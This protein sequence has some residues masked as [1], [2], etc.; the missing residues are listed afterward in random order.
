MAQSGTAPTSRYPHRLQGP[1]PPCPLP[2]AQSTNLPSWV[3]LFHWCFVSHIPDVTSPRHRSSEMDLMSLCFLQLR[4]TSKRLSLQPPEEPAGHSATV[5]VLTGGQRAAK[6]T[7]GLAESFRVPGTTSKSLQNLSVL[8]RTCRV[9]PS[10]QD[11]AGEP[12][13]CLA[14]L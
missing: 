7:S 2:A 10:S 4:K 5:S 8:T 6:G 1:P 9:P 3:L 12:L 11:K 14:L 13:P